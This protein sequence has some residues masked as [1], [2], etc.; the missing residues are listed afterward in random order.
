[1][2]TSS[3]MNSRFSNSEKRRNERSSSLE[4]LR[5]MD[6]ERAESK[7]SSSALLFT[8]SNSGYN[9]KTAMNTGGIFE[10]MRKSRLDDLKYRAERTK[11]GDK[12]FDQHI[13]QLEDINKKLKKLVGL[14]RLQTLA[15]FLRGPGIFGRVGGGRRGARG[16][17]RAGNRRTPQARDAR[18]RFVSRAAS[19]ARAGAP[20]AAGIGASLLSPKNLIRG[21]IIGGGIAGT[22]LGTRTILG[23]QGKGFFEGGVNSRAS[24]YL[25]NVGSG[26]LI[27]A[28]IGGPFG[29]LI[30]AGAGLA[31]A[32]ITDYK[33]EVI[34]FLKDAWTNIKRG[35]STKVVLFKRAIG[36]IGTFF[37]KSIPDAV[38]MFVRSL[39]GVAVINAWMAKNP[40]GGAWDATKEFFGSTLPAIGAAVISSI[41]GG[42]VA[43]TWAKVEVV[44]WVERQWSSVQSSV[45]GFISSVWAFT[46]KNL[47]FSKDSGNELF[48]NLQDP[49]IERSMKLGH[50]NNATTQD[51]YIVRDRVQRELMQK[52]A[53]ERRYLALMQDEKAKRSGEEARKLRETQALID[54]QINRNTSFSESPQNPRRIDP[55]PNTM[56]VPFSP[57]GAAGVILPMDGNG[58]INISPGTRPVSRADATAL[59]YSGA[60]AAA[61]FRKEAAD[62]VGVDFGYMMALAARES[63]FDPNARPI[64]KRTGRILSSATGMDQ[65]IDSTWSE[66]VTRYGGQY[67]LTMDGRTDPRQSSIASALF[68]R[69]NKRYLEGRLGRTISSTEM[70]LG[71]MLGIGNATKFLTAMDRNP[72][73]IAANILPTSANS[74]P[75]VFYHG[76]DKSRPRTF[77][78]IFD[79]FSSGTDRHS[80]LSSQHTEAFSRAFGGA[81]SAKASSARSSP[82]INVADAASSRV[83]ENI[84]TGRVPSI[85]GEWLR[86]NAPNYSQQMPR[87]TE[88]PSVQRPYSEQRPSEIPFVQ[89]SDAGLIV[90]NIPV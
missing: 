2:E 20:V 78:E 77:R 86:Q 64:D 67:G 74:N 48:K 23:N 38:S 17:R 85:S 76:S 22:V 44:P 57:T 18:G 35:F 56:R 8:K 5:L 51:L 58:M 75:H 72:N 12:R 55:V 15:S 89:Q 69:D 3:S 50:L 24:G 63:S 41:P 39:P 19:A 66:M 11:I 10:F 28:S 68:T 47:P 53:D 88:R 33:D 43:L 87:T 25:A 26:A 37:T 70:Y 83:P 81:S 71:H 54:T 84:D 82:N 60:A 59:S 73:G 62:L 6:K 36:S 13:E 21:G 4:R 79:Y 1:M 29:A 90:M 61:P 31:G 45:Q 16:G 65:F 27:G 32:L 9:Q 42:Q 7:K 80:G 40:L 34:D 49:N 52:E 46:L 30:G 14:V